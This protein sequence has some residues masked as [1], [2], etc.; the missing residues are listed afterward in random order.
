MER[1]NAMSAQA[2]LIAKKKAEIEAKLGGTSSFGQPPPPPAP[3]TSRT[4]VPPD[5]AAGAAKRAAMS[6]HIGKRWGFKPK[7]SSTVTATVTSGSAAQ[8]TPPQPAAAPPSFASSSVSG[9]NNFS[10][11]GSFFAQFQQKMKQQ[12]DEQKQLQQP[13]PKLSSQQ[14]QQQKLDD[15]IQKRKMEACDAKRYFAAAPSPVSGNLPA[16]WYQ[17]ALE[18]ARG[19]AKALNQQQEGQPSVKTEVKE[20][21]RPF[22]PVKEEVKSEYGEPS[23]SCSGSEY[24]GGPS[25][26]SDTRVSHSD[27]IKVED[28]E[29]L[30]DVQLP[31][32]AEEL[33][34]MVAVSGDSVEEVAK[35]H[36]IDEDQLSFLFDPTSKLYRRYRQKIRSLRRG[37][38]AEGQASLSQPDGQ[39]GT[40][41]KKRKRN[42]W[43]DESD[44]VDL[45]APVSVTVPNALIGITKTDPEL[46]QYAMKV[47]GTTDLSESQWKQCEDQIKMS[48]VY[49]Q[50]LVKKQA[51]DKL[52]QQGKNKH[53]YDSDEDT[54][55]GTWEHKARKLEM[56]KTESK[57][58]ELTRAGKGS[59]HIGDFLPPEELTKFMNKYKALK[60]GET[61]DESEYQDSKLT[62]SNLGFKMLE[63]MGWSEGKG[64]GSEGQGI[65][66][67]IGKNKPATD[68]K[69]LGTK[70][71]GDLQAEDDEFDAYRKRMMLAY[72]F[73]PN[74]LN[75]PRRA[76]Y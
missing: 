76:Y 71:V 59:H 19:I 30:S 2:D 51:M 42:R 39:E 75:N 25:T 68:N 56:A 48:L 33:A 74:P 14:Q 53:E 55:G 17:A 35:A 3:S 32:V 4:K 9:S 11:D 23:A 50:M 40:A 67:P 65:T 34:S 72:R 41:P 16:D 61:I 6:A 27:L 8:V 49:N 31:L 28:E 7:S 66:A 18:K 46:I 69:G 20:E 70:E 52:E 47:F 1:F 45:S 29:D 57:A 37:M 21:P 44:K 64:L 60:A 5:P 13:Q 62:Q 43:G 63:R 54:E 26:S 10:N 73:R 24:A 38:I 58:N 22:I 36:N 12:Q 15:V